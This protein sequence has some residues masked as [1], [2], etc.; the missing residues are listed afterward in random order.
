MTLTD[1]Q[2][3]RLKF[4]I[5]PFK[6]PENI[7]RPELDAL[8]K[9]V[10]EAPAK[11]RALTKGLTEDDLNRSYREGAWNIRQIINHLADM[12]L[13]HLFRM[14]RAITESD[15]EV[16]TIVDQHAWALT[17]DGL[18]APLTDS[19]DMF[20]SITKRYV[21]LMRA[22][23]DEKLRRTYFHPIRKI[24]LNQK[25]AIAM[26]A[27]HVQHHLEHIRIALAKR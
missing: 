14:K 3:T 26:S 20:E 24:S 18:N 15:Y 9:I 11:Y 27:W 6:A 16:I 8:I 12:Q 17:P 22:L 10:E 1:D 7:D 4:P 21:F 13:L 2:L 23:D 5:G 25:Q 19:L